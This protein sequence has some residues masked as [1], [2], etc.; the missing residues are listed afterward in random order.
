MVQTDIRGKLQYRIGHLHQISKSMKKWI[1]KSVQKQRN[2]ALIKN[3]K[4]VMFKWN[5]LV[6]RVIWGKYNIGFGIPIKFPS[7]RIKKYSNRS[8][9][10]KIGLVVHLVIWVKVQ[11]W[12]WNSHQISKSKKKKF[13]EFVMFK[14]DV[15]TSRYYL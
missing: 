8:I 10:K 13:I 3:N 6:Q 7:Q 14:M 9:K 1:L 11:Y 4:I 12:I 2:Y 15:R 5:F